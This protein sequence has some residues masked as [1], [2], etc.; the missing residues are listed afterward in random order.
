MVTAWPTPGELGITPT[1]TEV[2]SAASAVPLRAIDCVAAPIFRLLSVRTKTS[3]CAPVD[4]G[5]NAILRLQL[6]PAATVPL[7]AQ[8]GGVPL[9]DTW[10]KSVGAVRPDEVKFNAAL[11][12]LL[13]VTAC[14]V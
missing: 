12:S 5:V 3:A 11:P 9:P 13:A 14:G 2:E 8:S 6:A 10:L 4:K 7:L 1:A